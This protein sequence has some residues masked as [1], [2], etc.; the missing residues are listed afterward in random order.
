MGAGMAPA[1][2][3]VTK[4]ISAKILVRPAGGGSSAVTVSV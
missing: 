1:C 3:G 2:A 4:R